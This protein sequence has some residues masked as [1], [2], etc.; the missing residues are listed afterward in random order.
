MHGSPSGPLVRLYD[1]TALPD[2]DVTVP[3]PAPTPHVDWRTLPIAQQPTWPDLGELAKVAT[4]LASLPPLVMPSECDNLRTRL[5]AVARGEAFLLQGGDCAETFVAATYDQVRDKIKTL[6]QMAAVLTYGAS[7]P[8]VKVGR[9]AGQYAKPRSSGV[10]T[11]DGVELPSYRGD[12]V[13]DLARSLEARTPDP[14]RLLRAYHSAATTLNLMRAFATGGDADLRAVHLWNKDFVKRSP[15]GVRYEQIAA[16]IDRAINFMQAIGI[17]LDRLGAAKGVE[18]YSSH[19]ALLL[20]YEAALTRSDEH[21]DDYDL[22]AHM[23]WIGER[24]RALDGAHI[25]F[26][27]QINNP[28]G[29]KVGP[30]AKPSDAAALVETLDPDRSPG[31]LTVI[32]RLGARK[33]TDLLPAIVEAVQATGSQV[34]WTCDPMHGN[35]YESSTGYKTRHF[36]DVLSEVRG[37]FEVHESLGTIPGGIHIELTGED[38]TECLGGGQ[39]ISDADLAGRYETACDPRLNTGQSLELAFL[40]AEMLQRRRSRAS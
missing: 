14:R 35:T 31:R 26:A 19:E 39:A 23:V 15:A 18:L 27:Q 33:V 3:A 12:A 13:N 17:D 30:S 29:I 40:V 25:A 9:I 5:A 28:I 32:T 36:D 34:V 37:F 1:V 7:V 8:V 11:F 4:E 6:L 10:E 22:S 20:E 2:T 38:V 16:E 24:T 21:G